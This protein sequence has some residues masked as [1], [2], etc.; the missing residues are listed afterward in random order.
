MK[1]VAV[2]S[3][4]GGTGKTS[5]AASFA[6]LAG[7][8]V[9]ADCDVDAADLHL[10]L[11]PKIV[12]KQEFK[13]SKLAVIDDAKC[14][15]CGLCEEACRFSAI[16][17]LKIDPLLCEGCG[18]CVHVCPEAAITLK[19]KVAGYAYISE[20]KY[21]PLSHARLNAAEANSGKLVTL[22]RRNAEELASKGDYD[23]IL[24]D[25]S[26]GIGCPVIASLTGVDLAVIIVEP[27]MSGLHDLERVL[28]LTNHFK[29]TSGVCINFYDINEE[30]TEKIAAFCAER[31]VPILGKIPFDPSVTKAMVSGKPVV[32]C[33]PASPASKQIIDIWKQV[34]HILLEG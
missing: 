32:E 25:G 1:Q 6:V 9:V 31:G 13:G 23:L 24:I 21:G 20:T 5:L 30:N 34:K 18:V 3:G 17:D 4:K 29:I 7:K 19:E 28:D 26:P 12:S 2:V 14:I 33:F 15:K 11:Q 16:K 22:V 27:T 8:V 10:L